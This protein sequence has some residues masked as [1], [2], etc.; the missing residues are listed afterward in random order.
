[1]SNI[2]ALLYSD[3]SPLICKILIIV[4]YLAE[5][6]NKSSLTGTPW[7]Q[8]W[9]YLVGANLGYKPDN[10][11][12]FV[13]HFPSLLLSWWAAAK[14]IFFTGYRTVL[15]F[16]H[17][18][19][20]V[21]ILRYQSNTHLRSFIFTR[22]V[23]LGKFSKIN[24]LQMLHT[25]FS[26]FLMILLKITFQRSFLYTSPFL[27]LRRLWFYPASLGWKVAKFFNASSFLL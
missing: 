14:V 1:M 10:L 2:W 7:E 11:Y 19:K 21:N 23:L 17:G 26:V 27:D 20:K 16:F 24:S 12:R 9:N 25:G 5:K 22:I 3:P 6:V 8:H 4:S 15:I 13:L 18:G